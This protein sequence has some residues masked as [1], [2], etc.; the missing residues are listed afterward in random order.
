MVCSLKDPAAGDEV[1]ELFVQFP[2]VERVLVQGSTKTSVMVAGGTGG[3]QV[4]LRLV[5]PENFGAALLYFTGSKDH[6]VKI[7]TLAQRKNLTLNEWGLYKVA[8]YEKAAKKTAEAPSVRA[9]ASKTETDVYHHLGLPYIPPELREDRGEIEAGLEHHLPKLIELKDIQGDL[10]SHTTASDGIGTIEQMA[11]AAMARGYQFLAITDHSRSQVIANGLSAERLLKH[12]AAIRKVGQ[13][14]KGITLLVGTE[15]D[16]LADGHL[17]YEDAVLAELDVV[18]ASPHVALRQPID[19]ATARILRAIENPY[20]NV[21]GHPTGRLINGREGLPLDFERVFKAAR[22]HGVALE[23]NAGYPRLDLNDIHSRA[24]IEAGV[25][26]SINTNAHG[27]RDFE[28]IPMGLGVARHTAQPKNVI[29]CFSVDELK[30]FLR[31]KH[32]RR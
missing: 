19:K 22:D 12:A 32:P 25:M 3:L 17:D 16:I 2:E 29:N 18:V 7:R 6:N 9:V 8:D 28:W 24:A 20:V 1:S 11:E 10:H 13:R 27:P 21:I 30:K 4:D 14:I 5:P 23:I 15:V 26:L 31:K